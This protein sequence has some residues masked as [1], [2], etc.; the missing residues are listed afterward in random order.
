MRKPDSFSVVCAPPKRAC[1]NR[2]GKLS[3]AN[4]AIKPAQERDDAVEAATVTRS[5][6]NR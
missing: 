4:T 5:A 1:F 3:E 2:D 6:A